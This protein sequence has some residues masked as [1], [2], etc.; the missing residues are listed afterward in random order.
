MRPGD[1]PDR[2]IIMEDAERIGT[3]AKRTN[4]LRELGR[5]R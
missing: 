2:I 4:V 5:L 3:E 1:L